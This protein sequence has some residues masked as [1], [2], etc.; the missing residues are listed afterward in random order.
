MWPVHLANVLQIKKKKLT[1]YYVHC[2]TNRTE[3]QLHKWLYPLWWIY[4][5]MKSVLISCFY[6]LDK[7]LLLRPNVM[8]ELSPNYQKAQSL[9][10]FLCFLTTPPQSRR[11]VTFALKSTVAFCI[12][13][14][15][16]P[17]PQRSQEEKWEIF[18]MWRWRR[19]RWFVWRRKK[20]EVWVWKSMFTVSLWDVVADLPLVFAG[21]KKNLHL[22]NRENISAGAPISQHLVWKLN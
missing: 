2:C 15:K 17:H 11:N 20:E 3:T 13:V 12:Y 8:P 6:S 14:R 16:N 10:Q 5:T 21:K 7:F 1:Q 18:M 4:S 9:H 22:A 19:S